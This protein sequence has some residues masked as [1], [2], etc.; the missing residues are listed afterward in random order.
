[1][2]LRRSTQEE[3][4][5]AKVAGGVEPTFRMEGYVMAAG[6]AVGPERQ[7]GEGREKDC[8]EQPVAVAL[9]GQWLRHG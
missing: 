5:V 3:V 8:G 6:T 4:A 7:R 2:R 9:V 1:M